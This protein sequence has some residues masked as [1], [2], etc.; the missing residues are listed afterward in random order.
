MWFTTVML[1]AG[2]PGW[3][4]VH[5]CREV[6]HCGCAASSSHLT[7]LEWRTQCEL[8]LYLFYSSNYSGREKVSLQGH[9]AS[10]FIDWCGVLAWGAASAS[11]SSTK[12]APWVL[13]T[14]LKAGQS[15]WEDATSS[16]RQSCSCAKPRNSKNVIDKIWNILSC[17]RV[18]SSHARNPAFGRGAEYRWSGF[19]RAARSWS[20]APDSQ[21]APPI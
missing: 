15:L 1:C 6:R 13:S 8:H 2:S 4:T 3:A 12:A 5:F 19:S 9:H 14:S 11:H 7:A 16:T 21:L 17:G 20:C 18:G 10:G